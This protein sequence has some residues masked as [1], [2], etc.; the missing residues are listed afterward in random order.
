MLNKISCNMY[1]I[2]DFKDSKNYDNENK[3]VILH[4]NISRTLMK[5]LILPMNLPINLPNILVN[6][7]RTTVQTSIKIAILSIGINYI[8]T[9]NELYGCINDTTNFISYLK[10]NF[11]QYIKYCVQMRDDLPKTNSYYPTRQNIQNQIANFINYTITNNCTH[12]F[13]QYSDHGAQIIVMKL[14]VEMK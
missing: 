10:T 2:Q 9:P 13:F 6:S 3:L 11:N 14:M 8:N 5:T 12:I 7:I 1:I 4:N